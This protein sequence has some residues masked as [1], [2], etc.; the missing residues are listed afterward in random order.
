MNA[1]KDA[2]RCLASAGLARAFLVT[3]QRRLHHTHSFRSARGSRCKRGT[4]PPLV[5][6]ML[7]SCMALPRARHHACTD[8]PQPQSWYPGRHARGERRGELAVAVPTLCLGHGRRPQERECGSTTGR[9]STPRWHGR[10][11]LDPRLNGA[12]HHLAPPLAARTSAHPAHRREGPSLG[13]AG[14][15]QSV[16]PAFHSPVDRI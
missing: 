3:P 7:S 12:C 2:H 16:T 14:G 13:S 5:I 10:V 6:F 8:T 15:V 11:S 9:M 1:L 4:A